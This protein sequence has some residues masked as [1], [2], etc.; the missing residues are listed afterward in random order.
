MVT[1]ME[2]FSQRESILLGYSPQNSFISSGSSPRSSQTNSDIDFH[3]VFGGPPRR[4]STH[5]MR[6]SFNDVAITS[7]PK[8][9]DN[10]DN[11]GWSEKPVFGEES[12]NG[13][14]AHSDDFYDDIFKASSS[15]SSSPR[16]VQRDPY[17][18]SPGSRVL[19]PARPLPPKPESSLGSSLP[20]QFRFN[21][22]LLLFYAKKSLG[23]NIQ[24]VL[25]KICLFFYFLIRCLMNS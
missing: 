13:R 21:F 24:D 18:S 14:R 12:Y 11:E 7:A 10:D 20:A 3:D 19:S 25:S 23:R 8:R 5:E 22:T 1:K 2:R 17:A 16:R 9:D 15:V 6:Y 4:S